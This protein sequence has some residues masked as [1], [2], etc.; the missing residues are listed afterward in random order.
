MRARCKQR[1]GIAAFAEVLSHH[2]RIGLE[3]AA[4]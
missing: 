4:G 3:A 2:R 1:H